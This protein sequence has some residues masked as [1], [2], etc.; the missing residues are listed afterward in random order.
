MATVEKERAKPQQVQ[1][2]VLPKDFEISTEM[3]VAIS[4]AS[5]GQSLFITGRA[6][7]GKSTLLTYLQ[8]EVLKDSYVVVAPTG[9]AAINVGGSTIHKFFGFLPDVTF[10]HVESAEYHPRSQK[11]MKHLKTLIIDE[12][13]MVR[14]D[15]LDCVDKA[16]R[17]FGPNPN[18]PYGGVQVIFVGDLFQLS[19]I[20][21]QAEKEFIY[22][23]YETPFFFSSHSYQQIQMQKVVLK[24]V[25]RQS[26]LD[27]LEILNGI[28][29]NQTTPETLDLLNSR[30]MPDF[31]PAKDNFFITLV[32]TNAMAN[33]INQRELEKLDGQVH[34]SKAHITG[35]LSKSEYPAE[36]EINFK[37]GSQIMMLNN[38]A[39]NRWVN[40]TLA[41]IEKINMDDAKKDPHVV[42]KV[43]SSEER[44]DVSL[45]MWDIKRP[46]S[47]GKVLVYD[48]I[49]T[50]SQF[51]F[52]L[53]WAITIHKSQGKTFENVIINLAAK[54]FAAG[55][56]YVALSRC[57][58]LGGLVLRQPIDSSQVILDERVMDFHLDDF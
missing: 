15:L 41:T 55:Q 37:V 25:Y 30:V 34:R 48:T 9:V 18:K 46:R 24:K 16:L 57:T 11:I 50:F 58:T 44:Y 12:I 23:H 36:L 13:S 39:E 4:A 6:G 20:V 31:E 35:A 8:E 1:T 26:E 47:E 3:Q 33:T 38:D 17:R 49:G 10:Q 27:F 32:A 19:P 42:I 51:P 28:R 14:A 21:A 5:S 40:G 52:M 43:A 22:S 54:A 2:L 45:H 7:T 53:A 29:I 56:L